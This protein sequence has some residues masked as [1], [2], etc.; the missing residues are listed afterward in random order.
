MSLTAHVRNVLILSLTA[1]ISPERQWWSPFQ[2]WGQFEF[3]SDFNQKKSKWNT[4]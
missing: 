1:E 3:K 4:F 2:G